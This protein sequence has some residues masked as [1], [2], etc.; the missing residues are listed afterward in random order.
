M[1]EKHQLEGLHTI[2]GGSRATYGTGKMSG[3]G[4]TF[5][6]KDEY[7][8]TTRDVDRDGVKGDVY[9]AFPVPP[10]N[11]GDSSDP[12]LYIGDLWDYSE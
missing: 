8:H 2:V 1:F 3:H 11:G 7:K 5:Y 4:D 10:D 9:F 12:Y 6:T